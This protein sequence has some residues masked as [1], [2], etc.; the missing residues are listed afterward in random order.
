MMGGGLST[1]NTNVD[2][3]EAY[4]EQ[5]QKLKDMGFVNEEV[6]FDVLKQVGGNVDLAVERLLNLLG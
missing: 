3:K 4:K 5:N 1:T 6:N 2:P